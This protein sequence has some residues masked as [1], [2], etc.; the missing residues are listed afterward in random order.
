MNKIRELDFCKASVHFDVLVCYFTFLCTFALVE[1]AL[2]EAEPFWSLFDPV[3]P[4][5]QS[6]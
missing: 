5:V 1:E 6:A 3:L 2:G 4:L